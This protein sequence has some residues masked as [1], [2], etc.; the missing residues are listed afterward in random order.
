MTPAVSI[1]MPCRNA[2]ETV[3]AAVYSILAQTFTD[4]E[5]IVVDDGSDDDSAAR[6][7]AVTGS[8][9]RVRLDAGPRRGV[10]G[11]LRRGI[12]LAR[13]P[14]IARMDADDLSSPDRLER[15]LERFR[16]SAKL[17]LCGTWAWRFSKE[18]GVFAS[19]RPLD[20]DKHLRKSLEYGCSTFVH[21]TVMMRADAYRKT[22]GYR[23]PQPCEDYDLWLQL[24]ECGELGVAG[25]HCYAHRVEAGSV[26]STQRSR[27]TALSKLAWRLHGERVG[28]GREQTDVE[29]EATE[30]LARIPATA[31]RQ[32][33]RHQQYLLALRYAHYGLATEARASFRSALGTDGV[34]W[35]ALVRLCLL[36][37]GIKP[38]L[39][40]GLASVGVSGSC[41]VPWHWANDHFR[42]LGIPT[43]RVD[44]WRRR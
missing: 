15:Q 28:S 25:S 29:A 21:G 39:P 33:R 6:V 36:L 17:V 37:A 35:K 10:V 3:G 42:A 16:D 19:T 31:L 27:A 38:Y 11:A 30:I 4:F 8:D 32:Q 9:A 2:A 22:R 1:V 13:A 7:V 41:D 26:T 44:Q 43:C 5:L 24:S 23:M 14:F 40:D 12:A 20:D 34:G 18:L